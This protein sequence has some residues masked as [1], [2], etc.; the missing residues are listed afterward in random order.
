MGLNCI[1]L[2]RYLFLLEVKGI[3]FYFRTCNLFHRPCRS[4]GPEMQLQPVEASVM[5]PLDIV[6]RKDGIC[7]MYGNTDV[8]NWKDSMNMNWVVPPPRYLIGYH[9]ISDI[10]CHYD[11]F[12]PDVSFQSN[13]VNSGTNYP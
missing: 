13:P 4:S 5:L 10:Q 9:G 2:C 3:G 7:F 12:A 11:V 6:S 1:G 8:V